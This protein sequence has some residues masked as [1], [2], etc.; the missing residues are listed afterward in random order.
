MI[1]GFVDSTA[2]TY[3]W[4]TQSGV[5]SPYTI[6][7]LEPET[8]YIVRVKGN[9]GNDGDSE[10]TY[11]AFTTPSQCDV[12]IDLAA[13]DVKATSATLKWTGYQESFEVQYRK[14]AVLFKDGFENGLDNWTTID[15][16][17]DGRTWVLGSECGG[18][19][20]AAGGSLAGGGHNGSGDLVVSGS[21]SNVEGVGA[22]NP[23]NYLV[24]PLVP[25]GGT[26]QFYVCAQDASYPEEVFSILVS[27][28]GN[29]DT[30]DFT[31]IE[32]WKLGA[33][34]ISPW[35][36]ESKN[37]G[38]WIK[39]IVDLSDYAGQSGYVAIRHHDCSDQFMI[40]IDDFA[41]FPTTTNPWTTVT[42]TDQSVSIANLD[43]D[44]DYE[45][46]VRGINES[47]DGGY[48]DWSEVVTFTTASVMNGDA[49]GDGEVN[50]AD[51]TAI[52]NY[53][54]NNPPAG[55]NFDA[56]N[57]NG[58]EAIDIADVTAVINIIN[59]PQGGNDLK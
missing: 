16:D 59:Q 15:A 13:T 50:I 54:N 39:V 8:D 43:A 58:D 26:A 36:S 12:P 4:T 48:T 53:I 40:N 49:N 1:R 34:E 45:W 32:S 25:L 31:T 27:T 3:E 47:C 57:A 52:I 14:S 5:T 56:A 20:L 41:I 10:Y 18:V 7:G 35:S 23:D 30:S 24:S 51:V 42:T 44:S 46:Q 11:S 28:A 55:F 33:A 17:G 19:Y 9:F 37:Q 22:L 21:F 29:T 38:N 2:P 6:E